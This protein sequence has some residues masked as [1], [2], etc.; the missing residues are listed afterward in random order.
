MRK[1]INIES[2]PGLAMMDLLTSSNVRLGYSRCNL[3]LCWKQQGE[4]QN[5]LTKLELYIEKPN[6]LL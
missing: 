1:I 2:S 3:V 4:S 5:R 6:R